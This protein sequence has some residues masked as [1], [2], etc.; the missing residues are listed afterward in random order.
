MA[1]AERGLILNVGPLEGG[2]ATNAVPDRARAWGNVRFATSEHAEQIAAML[3]SL[4]TD[5]MPSVRVDRVFNRPAKPLIEPTRRLADLARQAAEDLGQ[6]LP[7]QSTGGVCDGNI[8]QAAGLATIDTVGV[9]GGGLH[10]RDEW[11]E[12]ASLVE[13]C[14]LL[15][16]LISRIAGGAWSATH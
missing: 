15:A 6:S 13:R 10:T 14:R 12:L 3:D 7:F 11:I 4:E 8:M 1:D 9:R 16:V 5:A 2:G